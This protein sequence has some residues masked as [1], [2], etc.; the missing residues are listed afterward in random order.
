VGNAFQIASWLVEPSL[1]SVSA[2][3]VIE[4]LEPKVMEVLVY[5][6]EHAGETIPREKLMQVVWP[7]TFVTD[8]V[9]T[10]SISE[11]RRV[12]QDDAKDPRYIQTIPKRGYRLVA[13]VIPVSGTITS[14]APESKVLGRSADKVLLRKPWLPRT[15]MISG[16]V[17][18]L[19]ILTV[20]ASL[21]SVRARLLG[22]SAVPTIH[23]LAVLPLQNLSGDPSQEYFAD[24]MTE[25]L[26]TELSRIGRLRVISR[27]SIMR[28]KK[29]DKSLP[30]IAHELNVDAIVE[31][32]VLRSGDR[33]RITAQL[34]YAPN[35][36]NLWAE[37]YDRDVPDVL[38]LQAS[39]AS[40]VAQEIHSQVAPREQ[41]SRSPPPTVNLAAL[42][43]YL[44]GQYHEQKYGTGGSPQERYKAAEYFR[45]ATQVDPNFAR[46][47][48][49]LAATY[50]T[51]VAPSPKQTPMFKEALEKAIVADPSL[52][53]A[54]YWLAR[55]KEYHDWDFAAAG[56]EF[57]RAIELDS[58]SALAHEGYGDYLDNMG[59]W[60]EAEREEQLAQTL[61]PNNDHL[62]DG[63][64]NRGEYGRALQIA[65]NVVEI[66]PEYG[67]NHWSLSNVY[68]QLG[69]YKEGTA[70][71]PIVLRQ[72]GYPEMA[73]ALAKTYAANGYKAALRL[74]AKDLAAVQGN[75]ACPTMV[76]RVYL[77]LGNKDETFKWLEKG[78][79]E[80]DGFLV[81]LKLSEFQSLH[82]DARFDDLVHRVGLPQ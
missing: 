21:R 63:L 4:R 14:A 25:E 79:V 53:D 13:P 74:Y 32:T 3:D 6:A 16:L 17:L 11:L 73:S 50:I 34:V 61:D 51:N 40:E 29:A 38:A 57:L 8:D 62:L 22:R 69:R 30:E 10:R 37:A 28:Y 78:F 72:Y 1:N 42:D 33:V 5:L 18:L 7:E 80:R 35:D 23:S 77:L 12:F 45:Q 48:V 75:P 2:R 67:A 43:A 70:E 82:G 65:R 19:V 81:G 46:A 54:H 58:N 24:G 55:F 56:R 64:Y 41:P 76:A 31:G 44:K 36:S 27:T 66:H 9:L 26:I 52:S 20:G 60:P 71:L 59:R 68:F 15:A 39:L 47:W 49:G